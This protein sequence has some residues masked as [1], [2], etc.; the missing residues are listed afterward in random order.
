METRMDSQA[1]VNVTYVVLGMIG[2]GVAWIAKVILKPWSDAALMRSE[3]FVKHVDKLGTYLEN[4]A[5]DFSK[6]TELLTDVSKE[7][8][9]QSGIL[10]D[11]RDFLAKMDSDQARICKAEELL[12]G[13]ADKFGLS[14]E[15]AKELVKK[16]MKMKAEAAAKKAAEEEAIK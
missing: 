12:K 15:E 2:A 7:G 13:V 11:V 16:L 9:V 3:A 1:W 4:I 5:R 14:M 8:K 10:G 6:Q